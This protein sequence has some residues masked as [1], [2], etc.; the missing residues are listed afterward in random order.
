[1]AKKLVNVIY[2]VDDKELIRLKS[3][4]G[5]SEQQAKKLSDEL[6]KVNTNAKKA[7]SEGSKSFL[8]FKN[9]ISSISVAGLAYSLGN[10]AKK[11]F[12]LG[13][14]Q[15]QTNIA[16]TTFLGSAEKAK[17][18]IADLTKFSIVTPFTP[19]QVNKAAKTLLAFGVEAEDV[20]PTLKML[21]DVSSGTGKDLAEMSVI[22][23]QIRSTG[24]L[25]GQD[26]LQLINAG[27][28]PL[29][30]ISQKTGRSVANLK[31]D[32]ENGLITFD[33][34]KQAFI[35]A[36]SAGG[37]FFNLME[38]Q[39]ESVGGKLST[40]EGNIEEIGKK[41]F[42]AKSGPISDFIGGIADLTSNIDE[43]AAVINGTFKVALEQ[44]GID[45][46]VRSIAFLISK[47]QEASKEAARLKTEH[48]QLQLALA[49]ADLDTWQA[50]GLG[51]R[52]QILKRILDL[53]IQLG[54]KMPTTEDP[55]PWADENNGPKKVQRIENII[56]LTR[57]LQELQE[58]EKVQTGN[59]L[60]RTQTEIRLINE[61]INALKN[62][63]FQLKASSF[64]GKETPKGLPTIS[65]DADAMLAK[66]FDKQIAKDRKQTQKE[67][68]DELY[69]IWADYT[70]KRMALE[71]QLKNAALSVAYELINVSF[72]HRQ[73]DIE[74]IEDKYN[75][76]IELAQGNENKIRDLQAQRDRAVQQAREQDKRAEKKAAVQKILAGTAV[77][78]VEA[79]PN[80]VLMALAA[81]LGFIQS[82]NVQ[83]LKTG[84]WV[85]GPGSE[86][87]DSVPILASRNE[88]M[89]NAKAAKSSRRL[90]PLINDRK[91]D[92]RILKGAS[93][94]SSFNDGRMVSKLS[95]IEDKLEGLRGPD[96]V[97]SGG[98]LFR[99]YRKGTNYRQLIRAKS[100]SKK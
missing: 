20:I 67:L 100:I 84:G 92:D 66:A 68:A 8:D 82:Q 97:E 30:I 72:N 49:K 62:L 77:N 83:R 94:D 35:D 2:K 27:F 48:L 23:G 45:A 42:E 21:G 60:I 93:Q 14:A 90:L 98:T 55:L 10:I 25:M 9:I 28:N 4:L 22:F 7:G 91:I 88:F 36:T 33:M 50:S 59:A 58:L 26:L 86:T 32:M 65:I 41:L 39:S 63:A 76:E 69:Q 89:V 43:L 71:D 56:T 78:I 1:M 6:N 13:V 40:I 61:K 74:G 75:K 44:S 70:N 87:S 51:D 17:K 11:I 37:L 24:R 3:A 16:F 57:E 46:I 54:I 99:A 29:Q 96:L 15:E 52:E 85:K 53:H 95:S 5:L 64:T 34:V 73:A 47:T 80:Y 31:K 81:T 12:D 79:F 18:L 38:K 19:D